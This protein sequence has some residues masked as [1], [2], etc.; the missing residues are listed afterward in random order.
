[1]SEPRAPRGE[2]HRGWR[3]PGSPLPTLQR[4]AA[5]AGRCRGAK[6][7]ARRS[8]VAQRQVWTILSTKESKHVAPRGPFARISPHLQNQARRAR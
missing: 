2:E 6:K 1:M 8:C 3:D 7:G 5:G 4:E